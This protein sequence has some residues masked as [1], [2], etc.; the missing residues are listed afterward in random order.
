[1][2]EWLEP[3][4]VSQPGQ[5]ASKQQVAFDRGG[6]AVAVWQSGAPSVVQAAA[7][8]PGGSFTVPQTLS[9]PSQESFTPDVAIDAHGDAVA[10]WLHFDGK[11]K[12]VQAAYRPA[13]GSFGTPQTISP[14]GFDAAEPRVALD[15][16]GDAVVVWSLKSGKAAKIQVAVA[17]PG[18]GFGGP[19]DLTGFTA[20]ERVPQV[21]FDP[22]GNA[23][24]VWEGAEG[25]TLRIQE[26]A[27]P[28]G[29]SFGTSQ[30]LSGAGTNA[31]DP[32]VAFDAS[33]DALAVW[34]YDGAPAS[35]IQA[36]YRPAG[37]VFG[38]P[39]TVSAS[40]AQPAQVPQV[41]FDG[42][43]SG[44]VTWQQSDGTNPRVLASVRS[45]GVAGAFGGQS[46]LDPGGQEMIKPRIAGDGL[47]GTIVSW[48]TYNGKTRSTQAAARTAGGSFGPAVTLSGLSSQNDAPEVGID[49]GGNGI[50][51]WSRSN[52]GN[53]LLEAAGYDA[54]PLLRGLLLPSQ[55]TVGQPLQFFQAPIGIW[56]PVLS[57]GFS[58]GDGASAIGFLATHDY[59]AAG[60]YPVAAIAT[61][62]LGNATTVTRTV[63]ISAPL[64]GAGSLAG[65]TSPAGAGPLH[66]V[67][68]KPR[69]GRPLHGRRLSAS[70]TC[71]RSLSAAVSGRLTVSVP[72]PR[73]HRR[74]GSRSSL[75]GYALKGVHAQL[76]AGQPYTVTLTLS[77]RTLSVVL[78]AMSR[79][80]AVGLDV[81][82]LGAPGVKAG[83]HMGITTVPPKPRRHTGRHR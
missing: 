33:G 25:A 21:A 24:A 1:M 35:T 39:V 6:D 66:C 77:A 49:E 73:R 28:A 67:L 14:A 3:Q 34:R 22:Y 59:G 74:H 15:E 12:R 17:P 43:G 40:S 41:A 8:P 62:A 52:G 71:S 70:L 53:F 69:H 7:R 56:K 75:L 26:S 63:V 45:P 47:S 20:V 31:G 44:V 78:A 58:F 55:G 18:G 61:D 82:V 64:A 68:A 72:R 9:D 4:A 79:H 46:I 38:A 13:G 83:A 42:L 5:D 57:E 30:F 60:S 27:M 37:G 2:P 23:I 11:N 16:S 32:Q 36:T 50:A 51:V 19:V 29:G 10:V 80:R 65:A 76:V 48:Q 54:G 81:T